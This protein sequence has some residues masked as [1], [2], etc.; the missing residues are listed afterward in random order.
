MPLPQGESANLRV[1]TTEVLVPTLVEKHGG[2]ILYGLKAGDFALEDNGKPQKI[3]VQEEM[4]TAPVALVVAVEQ[5][6][7]SVL[8]FD[9]LAKLGPLLDVFLTDPR[10]QAALVGFDSMPHLLED[11]THNGDRIDA[12]L[13]RLQPGDGG[14]AILDT[15]NYAVTLLET[16]PREFRR[17]LLLISEERD[18]GS[19]H[20]KPVQLIRKIGESDVL[21][22]SI[23]F[24]PALAELS[25]DAKDPEVVTAA[26]VL[27]AK[28]VAAEGSAPPAP[29]A[30]G[31]APP[32]PASEAPAPDPASE[33]PAAAP[34]TVQGPKTRRAPK[35]GT[36]SVKKKGAAAPAGDVGPMKSE[37]PAE[38]GP[39]VQPAGVSGGEAE[40]ACSG[41]GASS[42]GGAVDQGTTVVPAVGCETKSEVEDCEP[43][44]TGTYVLTPDNLKI[45]QE[46]QTS[47]DVPIKVRNR[48]YAALNRFMGKCQDDELLD[49]WSK[50][51]DKFSFLKL[52]SCDTTGR[53]V[54]VQFSE[55][56]QME[57][58]SGMRFVWKTEVDLH[59]MY[60]TKDYPEGKDMVARIVASARSQPHPDPRFRKD[61]AMRLYR[62]LAEKSES[63]MN[64]W[65][66]QAEATT[67]TLVGSAAASTAVSQAF[68]NRQKTPVEHD[69]EYQ[70]PPSAAKKKTKA[71]PRPRTMFPRDPV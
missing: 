41:G 10:S 24:S 37:G 3:H 50:S 16:E 56:K 67:D 54:K 32:A 59:I 63:E 64:R 26:L 66:K 53:Q 49:A 9:K 28:A 27:F 33:A 61:K 6:G 57:K 62:V 71:P 48:L 19:K 7:A 36:R 43:S 17:V 39:G 55:T 22:L 52:W 35:K 15:V 18:H 38:A 34:V 4:D 11:Y 42:G 60:K 5:G 40:P 8:E 69:D 65:L 45:M 68:E 46:A 13:E 30:E 70:P 20:T 58:N 44:G 29:A 51:P 21:V 12:D 23:S 47:G 1:S 25:H 2:G 31:P 14:A